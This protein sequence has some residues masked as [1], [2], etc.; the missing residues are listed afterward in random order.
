MMELIPSPPLPVSSLPFP[1]PSPLTTS[2]IDAGAPLGYRAAMIQ[3]RA[4]SPSTSHPLLLPPPIVLPRTPPLLPI[5]LPAASPPL[6]LPSTD[7]KA[8]TP[9]VTLLPRK[10]LCI[11]PGPRYEIGECSSA[12]TARPTRGFRADYGFVGTLNAEIRRDPDR[13]IGYGITDVWE[14]PDEIADEIPATDVA[15]LGQR[16]T[17]FITTIRQD[18]DEIYERL[19]DAQDD[20]LLM[21][22]QLNLLRR[23]RRSYARTA[24]LIETED[25][26]SRKAW[27]QSMDASDMACSEVKAL[28]TTIL[29]QQTKI[30]DLR[31]ADRRQQAQLVEAL[32]LLRTL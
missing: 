2:P 32:T 28:R 25:R 9:E 12:L 24:R 10:R 30:G 8:G 26:A 13:E 17:D 7:Y 14:D 4:E 1:V 23:D 18:T 6:L 29:A 5:P 3:L 27:V 11:A 22:G 21:S 19:D 31:A 20:R 15:E 16:M